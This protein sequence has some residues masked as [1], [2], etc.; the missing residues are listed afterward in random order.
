L[1]ANLARHSDLLI[2]RRAADDLAHFL[3][4]RCMADG[5]TGEQAASQIGCP[6]RN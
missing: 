4:L 5:Q 2:N 6:M 1:G 3:G